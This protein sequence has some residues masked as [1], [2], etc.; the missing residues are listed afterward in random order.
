MTIKCEE[1]VAVLS[2]RGG[3]YHVGYRIEG[4]RVPKITGSFPRTTEISLQG[5]YLDQL[6]E[7]FL[8]Y[9]RTKHSPSTQ[10]RY[11]TILNHLKFFLAKYPFLTKISHLTTEFFEDYKSFRK[12]EGAA[13]KTV[14]I[15]LR[16]FNAMF[17]LAEKWGYAEYTTGPHILRRS[18][19]LSPAVMI[20]FLTGL[21]LSLFNGIFAQNL[22]DIPLE[23]RNNVLITERQMAHNRIIRERVNL[24]GNTKTMDENNLI[25]HDWENVFGVD[26]WYPYFT[27]KDLEANFKKKLG[28]KIFKLKG[29]PHFE[30]NL[31]T[32]AF[33][34]TF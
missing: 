32:Y 4:R 2:Q 26:V 13:D 8:T 29:E 6:F 25:R 15:E 16:M 1:I 24:F 20:V 30:K 11:K 34:A 7:E 21:W 14:N 9:S 10:K 22:T 23:Q 17:Y 19:F 3:I 31:V 18:E 27:A 12:D 33:K 28:V 5:K